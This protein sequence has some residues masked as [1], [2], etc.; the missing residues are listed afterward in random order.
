MDFMSQLKSL[1]NGNL[2]FLL[3]FIY[4]KKLIFNIKKHEINYKIQIKYT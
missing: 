2:L 3:K 1:L 4:I